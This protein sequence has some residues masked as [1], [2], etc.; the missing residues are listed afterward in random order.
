MTSQQI[1]LITPEIAEYFLSLNKNNRPLNVRHVESLVSAI[2]RGEWVFNGDAIRITKSHNLIDGQHR[3]AAIV[4][5]GVPIQMLVIRGLDE[6]AFLTIDCGKTRSSSDSLNVIGY[7]NST[8]TASVCRLYGNYKKTGN[9][10]AGLRIT[11]HEMV[12]IISQHENI[13]ESGSFGANNSSKNIIPSSVLGF[14]H[15]VFGEYNEVFRDEFFSMLEIGGGYANNSTILLKKILTNNLSQRTKMQSA[16][17]CAFVFMAF[18]KFVN[19]IPV[20]RQAIP[21]ERTDWF[22]LGAE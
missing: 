11:A 21:K 19:K 14:S 15:F 16:E 1:I 2:S 9:P 13:I 5:S 3:L 17:K 18:N 10:Y 8:T 20:K 12:D 4:K 22:K 7:K 6:T